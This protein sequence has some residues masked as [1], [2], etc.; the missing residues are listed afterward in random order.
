VSNW[1]TKL[2]LKLKEYVYAIHK[3]GIENLIKNPSP[4]KIVFNCLYEKY[5]MDKFFHKHTGFLILMSATFSDP[6]AYLKDLNVKNAKYIKLKSQFDFSKSPIHFYKGHKINYRETDK[7]LPW[8]IKKTT[9]LINSHKGESGLIHS[10]SYSLAMKIYEKLDKKTRDRIIL[11]N[12]TSEKREG[13]EVFKEGKDK[14][15]LG[16]SL[17]EGLDLKNDLGRFQIFLKVPYLSLGNVYVKAKMNLNSKWYQWNAI[18]ALL[19]GVGRI[20]RND[21]DWGVTYIMDGSFVNLIHHN[22]N[23]FPDEFMQ[24]LNIHN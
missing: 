20:V 13:L 21:K 11:Y 10:G 12:G 3:T 17:L 1:L 7:N 6:A 23:Y 5:I 24:R 22:R 19:Q 9:D 14:V 8:L 16:P 18:V 15:L 2:K 4:E